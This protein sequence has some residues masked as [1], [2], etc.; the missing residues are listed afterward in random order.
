MFVPREEQRSELLMDGNK[1]ETT[2]V[3]LPEIDL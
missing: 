2:D 3:E 1:P